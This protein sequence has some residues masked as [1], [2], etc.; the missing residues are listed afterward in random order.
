[1]A[2]AKKAAPAKKKVAP[3]PPNPDEVRKLVIDVLSKSEKPLSAT[4]ILRQIPKLYKP[5]AV[6]LKQVL[7]NLTN[8]KLV[9]DWGVRAKAPTFGSEDPV[10]VASKVLVAVLREA[11]SIV[12]LQRLAAKKFAFAPATA[13]DGVLKR[14]LER[15][16]F[17]KRDLEERIQRALLDAQPKAREG[18]VV[19]LPDV[20]AR[21]S[22]PISKSEFDQTV[23]QLAR[24]NVLSLHEFRGYLEIADSER[25][26]LVYDGNGNY[27]G[28]VT[29]VLPEIF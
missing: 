13:R 27:Y 15:L 28:G 10:A 16:V 22:P 25:D 1:M 18:A 4:L 9:F 21:L 23:L 14:A 8:E 5:S 20:R 3:E 12:E 26:Q 6:F 29:F 19:S 24:D 2:K 11:G 7:E 17:G